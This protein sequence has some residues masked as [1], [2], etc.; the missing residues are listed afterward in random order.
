MASKKRKF[1][2]AV[3]WADH[4]WEAGYWQIARSRKEAKAVILRDLGGVNRTVSHVTVICE[5][6]LEDGD[7]EFY[8]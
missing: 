8:G 4:T 6:D 7:K 2:V 5:Q 3:L 1:E